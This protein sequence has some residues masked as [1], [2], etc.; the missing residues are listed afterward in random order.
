MRPIQRPTMTRRMIGWSLGIVLTLAVIAAL[1][2]FWPVLM[3]MIDSIPAWFASLSTG[4]KAGS[5]GGVLLVLVLVL[6]IFDDS[7]R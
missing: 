4:A 7:S 2:F 6:F 1:I 3:Q 5:L